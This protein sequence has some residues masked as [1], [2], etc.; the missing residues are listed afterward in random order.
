MGTLGN[1][2]RSAREE[3]GI[4]LRDAA[5]QTRISLQYLKALEEEDFSKL[6]GAVFVRGFLKNY[7]KFL[8]LDETE[9][10]KKFA[11]SQQTPPHVT[12]AQASQSAAQPIAEEPEKS[13]SVKFPFEPF[14]WGTV[15]IIVLVIALFAALPRRPQKQMP[16]PPPPGSTQPALAG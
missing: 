5:Q 11:E 14:V 6:P 7:C 16:R 10:M 8:K 3:R 1:Y 2:L 13:T 9:V 4:E 12:A 15:I